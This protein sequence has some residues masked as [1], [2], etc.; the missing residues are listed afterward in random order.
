MFSTVMK[1]IKNATVYR[2]K[3]KIHPDAVIITCFYNPKNSP[4]RLRAFNAFYETIKHMNHRVIECVIGDVGAQLT[5]NENITTIHT[6][7][8]LWHKEAL[9]NLIIKDLPEKFK[10]VFWVDADV[11]FSNKNWLIEGVEQ[12]KTHNIIQPFEYCIHLDKFDFD[13]PVDHE[14]YKDIMLPNKINNKVWRSFSANYAD[15]INWNSKDYSTHGHVGF[16]WAA[17]REI[18]DSIELYD[19]ALVGGAD[20]IIAHAAAGQIGFDCIT[21]AFG[22]NIEE[23]NRWS[24]RFHSLVKGKISY[25]SGGLFHIWHGDI[26]DR[27]YFKRIKEFTPKNKSITSKDSNGLYVVN[28]GEDRYVDEYFNKREVTDDGMLT[29]MAIGYATDSALIGGLVG[30]NPVGGMIGDML[31]TTDEH[32][33]CNC[34]SNSCV[35][36]VQ[37]TCVDDGPFS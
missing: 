22:E 33:N 12:L 14:K 27:Q 29:S 34:H 2:N 30:G 32:S 1:N 24:E 3:Y 17:R 11:L 37:N 10:Y 4:Y 13:I 7:S 23:I 26:A 16:A 8:L 9:L 18:L 28:T 15:N 5:P 31:N 21:K 20:H 6:T 25:V 19:H 35:E 36:D